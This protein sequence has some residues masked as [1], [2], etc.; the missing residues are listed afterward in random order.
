[1]S[2]V[3]NDRT[4]SNW[5]FDEESSV[6]LGKSSEIVWV[7]NYQQAIS[8]SA[9]ANYRLRESDVSDPFAPWYEESLDWANRA[10]DAV[11]DPWLEY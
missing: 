6:T 4:H 11:S 5:V 10:F 7:V 1:M 8:L 2:A 9:T 3:I